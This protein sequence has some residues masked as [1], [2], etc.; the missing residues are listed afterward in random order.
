MEVFEY[1]FI[2]SLNVDRDKLNSNFRTIY[3]YTE[4]CHISHVH[5]PRTI[6]GSP[7]ITT[8]LKQDL[9][10]LEHYS[11]ARAKALTLQVQFAT[12]NWVNLV[13]GLL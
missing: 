6:G 7:T 12:Y 8:K 1:K 4:L 13:R 2:A 10:R 9:H 3:K 11:Q 5:V